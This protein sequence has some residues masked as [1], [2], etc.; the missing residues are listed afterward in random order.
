MR[1]ISESSDDSE[2]EDHTA[3]K[4]KSSIEFTTKDKVAIHPDSST[5]M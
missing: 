1:W 2:D 3:P 5:D 4:K